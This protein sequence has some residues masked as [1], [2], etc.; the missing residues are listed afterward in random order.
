[1]ST[2]SIIGI[3]GIILTF[4]YFISNVI[5][6]TGHLS[7]RVEALEAWRGSIREDMHEISD[8]ISAMNESLKELK[9][10]IEERTE[11]RQYPRV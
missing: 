4:S 2:A 3:L 10:V 8:K 6:R 5:Y 1:M 11:K 7:A 9:T